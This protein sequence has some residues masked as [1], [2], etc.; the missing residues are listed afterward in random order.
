MF[1][2]ESN[3]NYFD[4]PTV[5]GWIFSGCFPKS[6]WSVVGPF[7][8]QIQWHFLS[9]C[10]ISFAKMSKYNKNK[11]NKGII[12]ECHSNLTMYSRSKHNTF[13]TKFITIIKYLLWIRI[14]DVIKINRLFDVKHSFGM[15]GDF[16]VGA[17]NKTW[18]NKL[19]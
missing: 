7:R 8:N 10:D 5:F 6:G 18:L 12:L 13:R 4:R 3:E 15:F 1:R 2:G 14:L 17:Q 19:L 11:R 9:F 16:G